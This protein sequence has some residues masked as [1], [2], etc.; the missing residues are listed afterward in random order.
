MVEEGF[1]LPQSSYG[2]LVKIIKGYGAINEECVPDQVNQVT[3]L[4]PTVIS[5]NNAFL[6]SIGAIQG[7]RKKVITERGR[8]LSR[9]LEHEMPEEIITHWRDLVK[10]NDFLFKVVTAVRIRKGMDYGTLQSHIAYSAG[11]PKSPGIMTGAAA[12]ID[13]LRASNLLKEDDGK[14]IA[15]IEDEKGNTEKIQGVTAP[16]SDYQQEA[17]IAVEQ[18]QTPVASTTGTKATPT[19]P[20]NIQLQIQVHCSVDDLEN[21][22]DKIQAMLKKFAK[23]DPR[24]TTPQEG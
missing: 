6:V 11:Q 1:R 24:N 21:L 9:A 22:P 2:E 15:T 8:S 5:R 4:H 18:L 23:D 7:G 12:V 13:I 3:G 19:L 17:A 16:F 10:N 14:L 20:I